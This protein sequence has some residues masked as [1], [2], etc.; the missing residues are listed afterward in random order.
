MLVVA[1]KPLKA[2]TVLQA[3]DLKMIPWPTDQLPAGAYGDAA[4]VVG[5]TVFD[6]VERR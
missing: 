1:A 4:A 6:P 5:N 2:G 3:T